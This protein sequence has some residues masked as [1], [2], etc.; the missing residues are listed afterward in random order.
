MN[1]VLAFAISLALCV[2]VFGWICWRAPE[3]EGSD[4]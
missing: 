3:V 2:A 4:G 1:A